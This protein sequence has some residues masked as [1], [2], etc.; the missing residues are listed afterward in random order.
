MGVG[1]SFDGMKQLHVA[2]VVDIDL[3]L[4]HNNKSLSVELDREDGRR[5]CQLANGGLALIIC[6]LERQ[7]ILVGMRKSMVKNVRLGIIYLGINDLQ[8]PG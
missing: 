5:E 1:T 7:L 3:V 8:S 4:Q 6:R 2:D